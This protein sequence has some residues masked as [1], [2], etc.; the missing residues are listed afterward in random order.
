MPYAVNPAIARVEA[1]PIMEAQTWIRPGLRNRALLN[2]CQAVPKYP[3]APELQQEVARAAAESGVSLYTDIF[4]LPDLRQALATHMAGDYAGHI[5]PDEVCI[6]AGCNM[7]FAATL[8]ALGGSGGNVIVPEPYFFNH[9]MWLSMLGLEARIIP[10]MGAEPWPKASDAAKLMDEQTRAIVLCTPNNPSGAIYPSKVIDSFFDLARERGVA[11]VMDETYKDFRESSQPP[12][13]L[14]TRADWQDTFVQLYSFS[15]A[16]SMTGYRVGSIIAGPRFLAEI[17]K[18]LD[19][20]HICAPHV[21]QRAALF[22]LQSLA[23]WRD[24]KVGRMARLLQALRTAFGRPGLRYQLVSSGALFAYVKHPF[25]GVPA[26]QVAMRLAGEH[27][28]LV[29]PGSMFGPGQDD[30]LRIAF[31][32]AEPADMAVLVDRLIESQC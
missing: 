6:T 7:A 5:T 1:P 24:E 11:L 9:T 23:Q 19:C 2:L 3:P 21:S 31:A 18:V 10:A 32:N 16:Y 26:K 17:E 27:D 4:G 13:G 28:V 25:A 30:Y 20:L 12:H 29:L 22:A 14:F 15:K 8:M